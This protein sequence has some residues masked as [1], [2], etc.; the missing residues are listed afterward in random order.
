MTTYAADPETKDELVY[1]HRGMHTVIDN[2]INKK[3]YAEA[4]RVLRAME[5]RLDHLIRTI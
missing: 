1:L 3:N 2:L 5:A 4:E